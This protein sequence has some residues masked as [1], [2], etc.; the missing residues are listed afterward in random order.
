MLI[1][2]R[3]GDIW[4]GA[5]PALVGCFRGG[6]PEN[7]VPLKNF[8]GKHPRSIVEDS[9]GRI[10]IGTQDGQLYQLADG[11]ITVF[12][13]TNGLPGAPIQSL[14]A[15]DEGSVWIGTGGGGLVLW[16]NGT[17]ARISVADGLPGNNIAAMVEDNAGRL[18]FGSQRGIFHVAKRELLAFAA[19]EISH[20]IGVAFSQNEGLDSVSCIS[21]SQPMACKTPDGRLWFA[22]QQGV[23]AVD[24]AALNPNSRPPPTFIDG[25]FVNDRPLE[26]TVPLR[27]PPPCRKIEF[28]FSVLSYA[29]PENIR[30]RYRL[31]GVDSDW[32]EIVRERDAVYAGLPPGKYRLHLKACNSDGVW[33]KTET[34][35]SFTVLPEWWQSWWFQGLTLCALVMASAL[36]VRFWSQR[37]LRMKLERLEHQQALERERTRIARDLHDDL[38]ATVT[39]VGLM[40]EE[41]RAASC[42]AEEIKQRS[43]AISGRVLNLARDLDA[44]VWSVNPGKDSLAELFTYLGQ[45]F[46]ECFRRTSIRP[47][48]EMA[49]E[50][51]NVTLAPEAR[52]NLFLVVKE[53][54]NNVIKHSQAREVSLRLKFAGN[55][56]EIHIKDDGRGYS[57]EA[58]THS[59]RNGV[60]NMRARVEHLGGRLEMSSEPG[61]GTSIRILIPSWRNLR[62]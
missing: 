60:R 4:F 53:A 8:P 2:S 52:N 36:G 23:L 42:S 56:L 28:H 47:R 18:W 9:K 41:L 51:P 29:A 44:V 24:A 17:F 62:A 25:I 59:K 50:V 39:Q 33:N 32:K 37:G 16:R 61:K 6:R 35:L 13:Q 30:I 27:V 54:L 48:L 40:L 5:D 20:V 55:A 34:S 43:A 21:S 58:I 38:G 46:L 10:W 14:Y 3:Q 7:Y 57:Q 31:D 19:G 45:F 26:I 15:D 12:N 1:K 22:T 49:D 11:K